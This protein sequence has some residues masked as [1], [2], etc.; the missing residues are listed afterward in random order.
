[1]ITMPDTLRRAA[2]R[3][4]LLPCLLAAPLFAA[5]PVVLGQSPSVNPSTPTEKPQKPATQTPGTPAAA[6]AA[7]ETDSPAKTA[8]QILDERYVF[9]PTAADEFG[10]RIAWQ[11][12]PLATRGS[13]AQ[14]SEPG[15][16]S[17]WF[18]DSAG[19]VVRVRRD[20]GE[21]VW[22]AST[23]K[24]MER[25][26]A[27]DHLPLG[28]DDRVY[29]V[30]QIDS[31]ALDALTGALARRSTLNQLPTTAPA[32]FGPY[33]VYGTRNGL[34][35]WYQYGT[36]FGW[37]ATTI[38]G[39][40]HA[41]P[42]VEGDVVLAASSKGNVLA[43]DAGSTRVVWDRKLSAGVE[44]RIATDQSAAFIAGKDQ[45]LWAFDLARGRV[46]WHYFTQSPLLNDP[47]RIADGL[48]LQIPDE[49]LVSFNPHPTDRPEGEV[50]WKST[51]PGNVIGR[52]GTNL[53]VWERASKTLSFV[54]AGNGRVVS[55]RALPQVAMITVSPM[56]NGD[57]FITSIDGRIERAEPLARRATAATDAAPNS[58][59]R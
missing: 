5:A 18:A 2:A 1:M 35:S 29:V 48:Y 27:I 40:V 33:F 55:Q 9:G 34:V 38:G 8:R 56:I 15:T 25:I 19:S 51:A 26:L 41:T 22:R 53:L 14:L 13:E 4:I 58:G 39:T 45:S 24:G 17:I 30:T 32:T 59:Q 10:Y 11:T 7:P 12:E 50:R 57:L 16:D 52:L 3:R 6:P 42:T 21:T 31:I 46:L 36:G 44:T 54:D 20:N 23:F 28:S 43:L 47:T 49:G 37:R